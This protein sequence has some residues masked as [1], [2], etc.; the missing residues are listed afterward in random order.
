MIKIFPQGQN[1]FETMI[2]SSMNNNEEE[3]RC[4]A[5]ET[6]W[7]MLFRWQRRYFLPFSPD[8]EYMVETRKQC[9]GMQNISTNDMKR[10]LVLVVARS[11]WRPGRCSF[12]G[13]LEDL[14]NFLPLKRL[15]IEQQIFSKTFVWAYHSRYWLLLFRTRYN[16]F[17][18]D[19]IHLVQICILLK[20]FPG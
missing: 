20:M 6:D 16:L 4:I 1:Y 13:A 3:K 15:R 9:I 7:H 11:A 2:T 8:I 10:F 18:G 14:Q 19:F 12:Y 17:T 5:D